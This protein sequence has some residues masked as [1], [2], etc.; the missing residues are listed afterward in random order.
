MFVFSIP[1]AES[2]SRKCCSSV[3]SE[4]FEE[5]DDFVPAYPL[6]Y[7]DATENKLYMH[8]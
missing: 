5:I 6:P 7:W 3:Q 4:V 1:K 2:L 8:N